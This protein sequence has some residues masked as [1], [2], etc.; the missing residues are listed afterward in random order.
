MGL[1]TLSLNC[2]FQCGIP[3]ILLDWSLVISICKGKRSLTANI[4]SSRLSLVSP[5]LQQASANSEQ[6]P[7]RISMLTAN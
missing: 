3:T 1:P 5:K 4:S 7:F 2:T 6:Q